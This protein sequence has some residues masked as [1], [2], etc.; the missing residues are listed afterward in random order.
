ML[1]LRGCGVWS[2]LSFDRHLPQ[3][4]SD[5]THDLVLFLDDLRT[6]TTMTATTSAIPAIPHHTH[7]KAFMA[8]FSSCLRHHSYLYALS[9]STPAQGR[10]SVPS[11]D[12]SG[13]Q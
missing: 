4:S 11:T 12:R 2:E 9:T 5:V 7:T 1:I 3:A 13:H 10:Y 6:T 8:L